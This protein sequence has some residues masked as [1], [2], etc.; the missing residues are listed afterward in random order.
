MSGS[1]VIRIAHKKRFTT[2]ANET[3]DDG[4]LSFRARGL[5][6]WLLSKPD[7][8]R[9]NAREICAFGTEGRDAVLTALKELETCGYLRREKVQ[10][11]GGR[12]VTHSMLYDS[13]SPEKP[14]PGN[15]EPVFQDVKEQILKANTENKTDCD[16][17]LDQF[18]NGYPKTRRVSKPAVRKAW[19]K[20]PADD[21]L[22]LMLGLSLWVR[23]WETCKTEDRW[24]P[25]AQKWL[26][27]RN[28]ENPP[29]PGPPPGTRPG[30]R[31]SE[32]RKIWLQD[33]AG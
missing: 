33:G 14:D 11:P 8:W 7:G 13:P 15:Q 31:W 22:A 16:E 25:Y 6:V 21:H 17:V 29:D 20:V 18:W 9:I 26:N 30:M 4:R 2:V 10:M 24:I 1:T 28:W 3:V 23:Y 12:W 19:R 5:I 32:T 27:D